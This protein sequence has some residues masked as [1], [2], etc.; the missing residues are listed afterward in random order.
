MMFIYPLIAGTALPSRGIIL[1]ETT[2]AW[3]N[4]NGNINECI[5]LGI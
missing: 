4:C 1:V 3:N 5:M 2:I